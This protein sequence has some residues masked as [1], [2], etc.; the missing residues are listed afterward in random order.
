MKLLNSAV[1]NNK[2]G[3]PLNWAI[4][5]TVLLSM[6]LVAVSFTIFLYSGAYDTVK[7]IQAASSAIKDDSIKDLDTKSPVQAIDLRDYSDTVK[8][9][10]LLLNDNEDFITSELDASKLGF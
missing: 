7:Q 6:G 4:V 5:V 9:R 10:V 2:E 1:F 3:I 8:N